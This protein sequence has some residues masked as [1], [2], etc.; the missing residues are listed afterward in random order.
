MNEVTYNPLAQEFNFL[1]LIKFALPTTIMMMFMSLYTMIDGIFISEFVGTDALAA[2]NIAYPCMS[3]LF[4]LGLMFGAGGSAV[5]AFKLGEGKELEAK[6]SFTFII[7]TAITVG[8]IYRTLGLTFTDGIVRMLGTNDATHELAKTYAHYIFVFAPI[9]MLQMSFSSFFV[10][11]GK[12]LLGLCAT[13]TGGLTNLV[14]DYVFIVVMDM[15]LMGASL[16]TALGGSI[17]AV[18]GLIY[19]SLNRKGTLH[20]VKPTLD[21]VAVAKTMSNGVSE[22]IGQ[23]SNATTMF[24]FNIILMKIA[25]ETGVAAISIILYLQFLF[26]G[27]YLGYSQGCAPIMSFKYGSGDFLQLQKIVKLSRRFIIVSAVIVYGVAFMLRDFLILS[28]TQNDP[29]VYALAYSGYA[30]YGLNILFVGSNL[31]T[32]SMFTSLSNGKVSAIVSS[33]RSFIFIALYLTILPYF[34]GIDGVWIAVPLAE[35][36]TLCI[37]LIFITK[38]KDVYHYA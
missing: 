17:P 35:I 27:I 18:T 14:L 23:L 2:T 10:A 33:L 15:G 16:G 38:L 4:G 28:F 21:F 6:Q 34:F 20:F 32:S 31:F 11:S 26:N 12:P 29:E 9:S 13:V 3:V 1:K 19:F 22:M 7:I 25:G 37:S 24:M 36:T 5:V 30:I 8:I